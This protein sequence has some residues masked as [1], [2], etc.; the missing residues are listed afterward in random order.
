MHIELLFGSRY[1]KPTIKFNVKHKASIAFISLRGVNF[2][3]ITS[4][5]TVKWF[6][7]KFLKD[8]SPF[9]DFFSLI[10]VLNIVV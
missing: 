10:L 8:F 9:L 1:S 2:F 3:I 6:Y 7:S 4:K 5:V